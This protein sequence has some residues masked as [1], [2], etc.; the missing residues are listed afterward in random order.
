M[1]VIARITESFNGY[2]YVSKPGSEKS[3]TRLLQNARVFSSEAEARANKCG[4]E[5][6]LSVESIMKGR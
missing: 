3:Y 4:N 2:E 5:T 1:Y 6:V